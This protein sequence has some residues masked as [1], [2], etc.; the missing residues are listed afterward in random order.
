[1]HKDTFT[2]EDED[3]MRKLVN[4]ILDRAIEDMKYSHLQKDK[5][6]DYSS[7]KSKQ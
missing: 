7:I 6:I 4:L 5:E 3:L 2:K 1:M